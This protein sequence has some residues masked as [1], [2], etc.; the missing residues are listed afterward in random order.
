MELACSRPFVSGGLKK[1]ALDEWSLVKKK[2][3]LAFLIVL[4]DREPGTGYD[5][6]QCSIV[7]AVGY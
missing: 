3:R 4:T 7:V 2:E 5:G 1:Q 6:I